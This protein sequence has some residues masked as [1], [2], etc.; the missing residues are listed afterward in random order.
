M[1]ND[2]L[3]IVWG[4]ET[5]EQFIFDGEQ[6]KEEDITSTLGDQKWTKDYFA[7]STTSGYITT[8]KY[9][10][11]E[12]VDSTDRFDHNPELDK[13]QSVDSTDDQSGGSQN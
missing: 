1:S 2:N 6:V 10:P 11:T 8:W 7:G 5:V 9:T 13:V 3:S 12:V 4:W